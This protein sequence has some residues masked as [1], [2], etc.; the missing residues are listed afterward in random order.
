MIRAMWSGESSV[1]TSGRSSTRCTASTRARRPRPGL[2]IWLGAYGPRTLALTGAQGR[3][4]DAVARR[5]CRRTAWVTPAARIDDAAAGAGRDPPAIRKVYNLDGMIGTGV[6]ASRSAARVDQW[7]D[8]IV[9]LVDEARDERVRP[10]G[11]TTTTTPRSPCS[12]RRSCRRSAPRCP[13]EPGR[14]RRPRLAPE[15]GHPLEAPRW[16]IRPVTSLRHRRPLRDDGRR[17][18]AG[19][20]VPRLRVHGVHDAVR[21]RVGL[22]A[23]SLREAPR[24][25][26][27]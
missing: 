5:S 18:R 10:T 21:R 9:A 3:R 4:V 17:R 23:P 8:D 13:V 11:P 16:R 7:V 24:S 12:P 6:R 20:L 14:T 22:R 1:R 2:G 25:T 15:P 26:V 19:T 27:S